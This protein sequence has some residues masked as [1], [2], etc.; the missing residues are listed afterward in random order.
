ML[1]VLEV[2]DTCHSKIRM[3]CNSCHP[4]PI[5]H[6]QLKASFR[7]L[8]SNP[9]HSPRSGACTPHSITGGHLLLSL[10]CFACAVAAGPHLSA[11]RSAARERSALGSVRVAMVYSAVAVGTD[12]TC[13]M[14]GQAQL[15]AH[16]KR[17][18]ARVA[19]A[20]AQPHGQIDSRRT[21]TA[22][23]CR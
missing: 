22:S 18:R 20:P 7:V 13:L 6:S 21:G 17:C 2:T 12:A 19:Q 16:A 5:Q 1:L 10:V 23:G 8:S 3:Q 15:K 11:L 9:E 4:E 14:C